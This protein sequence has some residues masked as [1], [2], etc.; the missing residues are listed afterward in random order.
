MNNY[1]L[2]VESFAWTLIWFA[3]FEVVQ[4]Y[5]SPRSVHP[6]YSNTEKDCNCTTEMVDHVKSPRSRETVNITLRIAAPFEVT[7]ERG[8]QENSGDSEQTET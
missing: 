4:I 1:Q 8:N 2:I 6:I 3:L 7:Q 5:G